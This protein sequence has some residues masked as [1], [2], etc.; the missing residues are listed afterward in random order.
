M[1]AEHARLVSALREV[2]SR[3]G[4]SLTALAERTTYSRSSWERYLNGKVFPPR[5]AVR[6]LCRVAD[7]PEGRL[8]ALWEIAE[9]ESSGRTSVQAPAVEEPRPH[10]AQPSPD[11]GYSCRRRRRRLM[12]ALAAVYTVIVGSVAL[13][14]FL[15]SGRDTAGGEPLSSAAPY[16]IG[17][18]CHGAACEGKDPLRLICGITPTTLITHRTTTGAHVEVRHS[19]KCGAGWVRV[20][21]T[22]IGDRVE[23]TAGGPTHI[24]R[25]TTQDDTR[26]YVY[27]G[28]AAAGP[29][30][31]VRACFRP[32]SPD[33]AP[34]CVE[35]RVGEP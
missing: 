17:P 16:S 6:E 4:L 8:A 7:E 14:L 35:A 31:T 21:G 25:I 18:Q 27:T 33:A 20:W 2:R 32:A 11:T 5:Q 34:E 19:K 13:T 3:T 9:A 12:M 24:A 29:G 22:R 28:M 23:V 26:T 30:D 1:S 15:L 10:P